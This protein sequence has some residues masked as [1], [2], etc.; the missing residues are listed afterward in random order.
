[1]RACFALT[2]LAVAIAPAGCGQNDSNG[3][4]VGSAGLQVGDLVV[5]LDQCVLQDGPRTVASLP[6]GVRLR[7]VKL[8]GD[9]I[10]CSLSV[11][12]KGEGGWVKQQLVGRPVQAENNVAAA[13]AGQP[14]QSEYLASSTTLT[15]A[16]RVLSPL[17]WSLIA[18]GVSLVFCVAVYAAWAK[19]ATERDAAQEA[20]RAKAE[21]ERK[22]AEAAAQAQA[23]AERKAAEEA[24][25]RKADAERKAAEEAA[26][27]KA[28]AERKAA[29]EAARAKAE[30]ERK[31][32]EAAAQ[33]QAAAERKAA[34]EAAGAKAAAEHKAAE[35]VSRAK[36]EA[37]KNAAPAPPP[38]PQ[39]Q[40]EKARSERRKKS[41]SEGGCIIDPRNP[42]D[43]ELFLQIFGR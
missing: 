25:R 21:A 11:D 15:A 10:G 22:A 26:R 12:G 32:A 6:K 13:T 19:S 38:A 29:Q 30:A 24:A 39:E 5:T 28:E 34:E 41:I 16:I 42:K 4:L 8:N 23:A 27:A 14:P 1:M 20:A 37:A 17:Q 35:E 3:V 33:A 9:W 31:A 7:V 18:V 2:L 36:V 40:S 43:L